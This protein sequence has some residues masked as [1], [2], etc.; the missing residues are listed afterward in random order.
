MEERDL[1]SRACLARGFNENTVSLF[2]TY[3]TIVEHVGIDTWKLR[4][5]RIDPTAIEALREAN[6]AAPL[7]RRLL[8]F[9]RRPDGKLWI[10]ARLPYNK[11]NVVIGIPGDIKRFLSARKFAAVDRASRSTCGQISINDT[12]T[13]FGYG[14]FLR[15]AGA[16]P[17]DVLLAEFDLANDRVDLGLTDGSILETEMVEA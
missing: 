12:G 16:D 8:R 13:S 15:L 10:A 1:S 5:L 2:L 11:A 9:G 3:S 6:A 14:H 4:G 7:E 17:D